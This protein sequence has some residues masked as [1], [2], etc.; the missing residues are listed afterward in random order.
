MFIA[1]LLPMLLTNRWAIRTSALLSG[2]GIGLFID[3]VGK[4]I[5]QSNDYFFPP[6][7]SLIY[8]F[9][10][11]NVLVYFYFRR[12]RQEE[13]RKA[14]YHS[15]E[16]LQ[17]AL[18]GDL[19]TEEAARIEAHLAIAMRSDQDEIASLAKTLSDYLEKEK[20]QLL[21][22]K[23]GLW[24]RVFT[25][26]DSLGLM[27]GRRVYRIIISVSLILWIVSAFGYIALMIMGDVNLDILIIQ[28]RAVLIIIQ[29]TVGGLMI[30]AAVYWLAGKEERGLKFGIWGVLLSLVA[31]QLL[32]FYLAQIFAMITTL[33]QFI[34]LLILTS[35]RRW[36]FTIIT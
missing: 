31:L 30:A 5:S 8:G 36:Y 33:L 16:E 1:V 3:E 15:L 35:Y 14:M 22:A 21:L 12:P 23:P 32:S 9:F 20:H 19:D 10:L 27:L 13:P 17:E 25:R 24:K 26:L 34:F 28:W 2:I 18:D 29:A 11:L 6:A 7:L 4:F